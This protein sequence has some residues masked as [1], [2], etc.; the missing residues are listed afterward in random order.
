[1]F[2]LFFFAVVPVVHL[3]A[4]RTIVDSAYTATLNCT[5]IQGKPEIFNY[6]WIHEGNKL[7]DATTSILTGVDGTKHGN[8]TCMVENK[9][10]VAR[11]SI[12]ITQRFPRG[13]EL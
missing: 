8:Y 12:L 10:G 4:D 2:V 3:T 7:P 6:T 13:E 5:I 9:A 11:D 1:M